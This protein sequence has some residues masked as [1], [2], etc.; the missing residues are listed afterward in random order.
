MSD[1]ISKQAVLDII[2]DEM[3]LKI[4]YAADIVLFEV[5]KRVSELPVICEEDKNLGEGLIWTYIMR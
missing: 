2:H 3:N 4:G 5:K 1:L